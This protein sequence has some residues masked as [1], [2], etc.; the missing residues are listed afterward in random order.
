MPS[1]PALM[2]ANAMRLILASSSPRR[3]QLL[4]ELGFEF[5]IIKPQ[6]DESRRPD[7]P[8]LDFARRLSREKAKAA[9]TALA[10][11]PGLILSA[12]TIVLLTA[13]AVDDDT[14]TELLGK[15]GDAADARRMLIQLR[16][17]PHQV[18]TAFTLQRKIPDPR[19][20]TRHERTIVH[21]RAYSDEEIE[22]YIASGDPFDKAGAY[23]IQNEAFHPVARIEGSY[24][25]VVGLPG[26]AVQAALRDIGYILPQ[27]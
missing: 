3:Q 27:E 6:I 11:E 4:A 5:D 15:P 12:D 23:A 19:V 25:N 9:A 20:I 10:D 7:E 22:R 14:E 16:D 2:K 17:R 18:I 13:D 1:G 21:M 8:A 26:E 24:S